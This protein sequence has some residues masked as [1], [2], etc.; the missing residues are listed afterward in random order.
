MLEK[1]AADTLAGLDA[2]E[3]NRSIIHL[4]A[5]SLAWRLGKYQEMHVLVNR[6]LEGNPPTHVEDKLKNL[7]SSPL[8]PRVD[9]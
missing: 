6:A 9:F 7:L 4:G 2:P 8:T 5:A 1:Q 3:P